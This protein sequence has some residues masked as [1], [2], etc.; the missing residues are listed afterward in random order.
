MLFDKS[1]FN[2][3]FFS[4]SDY[5]SLF[6]ECMKICHLE[7]FNET[8]TKKCR[9]AVSREKMSRHMCRCKVHY[10]DSAVLV[11]PY[12]GSK[13]CPTWETSATH[14]WCFSP[15]AR[16]YNEV[17]S[18]NSCLCFNKVWLSI[19]LK[20]CNWLLEH[21]TCTLFTRLIKCKQQS[22]STNNFFW[23]SKTLLVTVW[24]LN[25]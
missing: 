10:I 4:I 24:I 19:S 25:T 15:S 6:N 2:Q 18:V 20:G 1:F 21:S 8:C 16:F 14:Q 23:L 12:V 13:G 9:R 17:P 3:F 7:G 22:S 11:Y 5:V